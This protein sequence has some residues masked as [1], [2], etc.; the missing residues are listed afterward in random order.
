MSTT[1]Q[2]P[3]P[4]HLLMATISST[5]AEILTFP[6]DTI[7]IHL[8]LQTK[9]GASNLLNSTYE[10]YS[11]HGFGGYYRGYK[12]ALLRASLNSALSATLYKPVRKYLGY[13][14]RDCPLYIKLTAGVITGSSTQILAAPADL[15]KV[16]MQA[17]TKR[18]QP[19]YHGF[20]DAI[21]S[22]Y[23]KYGLFAFWKGL[24]PSMCRAGF[25]TAAT[26]GT[27]DHCK[28]FVLNIYW[29]Q[30]KGIYEK[31]IRLHFLCSICSSFCTTLVGC[32]FDVIKTRYQSQS[33][34]SPIYKSSRHCLTMIVKQEGITVLFKGFV[35]MYALSGPWQ[36]S[37]FVMFEFLHKQI[38]GDSF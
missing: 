8:Q 25:S 37:F 6:I 1:K 31:D 21:K 2:A 14:N 27:Y 38:L 18:L 17:D 4:T 23:T 19:L 9:R 33:F 30:T 13:N 32:P 29:F 28:S 10:I 16:R 20:G 34:N 22:I 26:L 36:I 24:G 3:L 35:P 15:L 5:F 11:N 7:K 12:P